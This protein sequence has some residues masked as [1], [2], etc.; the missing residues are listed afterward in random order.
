[1]NKIL[2]STEH[3]TR[4]RCSAASGGVQARL[5]LALDHELIDILKA[6]L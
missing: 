6:E 5:P 2:K 1:M 3:C 4:G